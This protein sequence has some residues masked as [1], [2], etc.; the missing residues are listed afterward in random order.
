M[1]QILAD[2]R[3]RFLRFL[4]PRVGS[5]ELAEEIL[6]D[7]LV[8][9]MGHAGS[10]RDDESAM[11][12][13]YRLLRNTLT[14]HFRQQGTRQRAHDAVAAQP[15]A[16]PGPRRRAVIARSAPAWATPWPP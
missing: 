14:D 12:W 16:H 4:E 6:H 15:G 5:R 10:L 8:R 1:A 13:F 3:D 9:G 2:N 11:A 7:A